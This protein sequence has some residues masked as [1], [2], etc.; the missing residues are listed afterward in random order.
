MSGGPFILSFDHADVWVQPGGLLVCNDEKQE[1]VALP[2]EHGDGRWG[3][4]HSFYASLI[5]DEPPPADGR[6]GR[7]TLEVILK[8][9]ESSE[10]RRE[11]TLSHQTPTDDAGLAVV[12]T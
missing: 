4:V 1:E 5:K 10:Q 12:T 11:V 7:A 8:I 2:N 9:F 3:R 6:W